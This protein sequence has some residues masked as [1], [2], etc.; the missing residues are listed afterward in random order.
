MC[1][2]ALVADVHTL[3][4]VLDILICVLD[5]IIQLYVHTWCH[6][7]HQHGNK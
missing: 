3:F 7:Q 6:T 5:Q 2:N 4:D 1:D